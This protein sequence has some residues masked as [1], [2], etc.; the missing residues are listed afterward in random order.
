MKK[1]VILLVALVLST[2]LFASVHS[3]RYS[4]TCYK[5]KANNPT[6]GCNGCSAWRMFGK[7][8]TIQ[9]HKCFVYHCE[10]GHV[11]YVSVDS[12]DEW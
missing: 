12:D 4:F 8:K 3:G 11:L 1:F 7:Q 2:G 6:L 10:H 9:G 5:C